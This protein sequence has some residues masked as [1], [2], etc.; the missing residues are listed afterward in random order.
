M[1]HTFSL[2]QSVGK[3]SGSHAHTPASPEPDILQLKLRDGRDLN[4]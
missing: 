3:V 2:A 4:C 1:R